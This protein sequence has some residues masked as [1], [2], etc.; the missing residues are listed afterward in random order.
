[1]TNSSFFFFFLLL[2]CLGFLSHPQT[3]YPSYLTPPLSLTPTNIAMSGLALTHP[4]NMRLSSPQHPN[5]HTSALSA[6]IMATHRHT[7]PNQMQ[8][9]TSL[10]ALSVQ[11]QSLP[12]IAPISSPQN[13]TINQS[14]QAISGRINNNNNVRISSNTSSPENLSNSNDKLLGVTSLNQYNDD[15]N[16]LT[17]SNNKDITMNSDVRTNSIATLRIKAKEHLESINKGLAMA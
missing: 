12:Q 4:Q 13:L 9:P 7:P 17:T 2:N 14:I 8:I 15:M 11:S 1:M 5:G 10:S 3:V 6:Q 16:E